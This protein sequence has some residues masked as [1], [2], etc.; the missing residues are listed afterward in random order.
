MKYFV[1]IL[2]FVFTVSLYAQVTDS[3][4]VDSTSTIVSDTTAVSDSTKKSDIDDIVYSD[5]KDSLTF[6]V[7]NKMMYLYGEGEIKYKE[8]ELKSGDIDV[9]FNS[10]SV[11][12]IGVKDTADTTGQ[13]YIQT[14]V[15]S[16]GGDVY[17]G[18]KLRY[19]FKSK[20]GFIS[21]AKNK[22][23]GSR[24]EGEKVKKVD[25]DTYFIE[26]GI[27]TTCDADTP[28]TH[29]AASKMKL[30]QKDVIIA[31]W[32][33]M[34]IEGIP[35]PIPL[36]FAV[37]PTEGGRRS[38]IIIPTY[39]QQASRG[40]YFR[41]F[42]YFFALSDYFDLTLTGDYYTKG[43]Y[44]AHGRV[45]YAKR[46]D[47]SGNINASFS[48][49]IL[50]EIGD[51]DRSVD[52]DWNISVSHNQNINPTTTLDM[53]LSFQSGTYLSNNS[54]SYN[55]ILNQNI[56]SNA[57]FRKRWEESGTSLTLNYSRNQNLSTGDIT[58]SLPNLS[59]NK[60]TT[61]PFRGK[62]SGS[63]S[64][65]KWY[66]LIGY[67]YSGD[68]KNQRNKTA[69]ELKIRGGIQHNF[70]V[71]ASPKIGYFNISP[72][73]GYKE[74][75]YNKQVTK[76]E[77]IA[78]I[79]DKLV[80]V[81]TDTTTVPDTT[82]NV[83]TD[84]VMKLGAVRTFNMG[85][86][87]STKL[88]GMFQPNAFGV[89][90]FRHTLT[91]TITY[92]YY[93]DFSSDAWGYYNSYVDHKG[94]IVRYDKYGNEV[95]QGASTGESQ[96]L[97]FS[98][99]NIFEFKTMKDPT[100]TTSKAQKVR[101]LNLDA[102][103]GYNLAADSINLSNLRIS[104]RTDIGEWLNLDA[105]TTYTFY[106]YIEGK[107]VNK[108]LSSAGKGLMRLTNLHI[109]ASTSLSGEKFSEG[110]DKKKEGDVEGEEYS[111]FKKSDLISQ[112]GDVEPDFTI[113]WN[114]SLG[115]NYDLS[116]STPDV[117]SITSSLSMNLSF[118]LSKNWKF[119]TRANYD[120]QDK[121]FVAPQIT[122]NRD[123]HCW[124]MSFS[125]NPLGAYRGFRFEIRMKA[126]ELKDVKVTKSSG[127]YSG[128]R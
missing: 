22:E 29:F 108:F 112:Y 15:L 20:R 58:E 69:G 60:T 98:L 94:Q 79:T 39:G 33:F 77:E 103:L 55:E 54:T 51:P 23:E 45:R 16:D 52:K 4:A 44:G 121:E 97:G 93:P 90:A 71:S 27:Y 126:P 42:G 110:K 48:K 74:K 87:L 2:F 86:S 37:F 7:K 111:A 40:W 32:I 3:T 119:T 105:N 88:Y 73:F 81:G 30:I 59:F 80:I 96:T 89:E 92:S 38:G 76:H 75:W 41:N 95:F 64:D 49:I 62:K 109:S 116:K 120:F 11:S 6:D 117:S 65:L 17:E 61:Y 10:N 85:V 82:Y 100:D 56:I 25:K 24:Y 102:S 124:E 99:S 21:M 46:Y 34:Y 31:R 19:N 50:G 107:Q 123:L 128:R 18:F 53:N 67:N 83:I 12:A 125:W 84:D 101:L 63:T 9:D 66:E 127:L 1:S 72:N 57:T 14:P 114:L 70:S 5:A 104:Y 35:M 43:G 47:F 13:R 78:A 106:D 113:P 26:N 28:H 8:T 91:P 115:Y 122:I 68:F 118:S 36:P